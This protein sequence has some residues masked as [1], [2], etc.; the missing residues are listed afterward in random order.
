MTILITVFSISV[1]DAE[2]GTPAETVLT[3]SPVSSIYGEA[4]T[5]TAS[6][7]AEGAPI[8]G[9][10]ISFSLNGTLT[11]TGTTGED[12]IASIDTSGLDPGVYPIS[13]S[14]AGDAEYLPSNGTADLTIN[15]RVLTAQVTIKNKVY[16]GNTGATVLEII[17]AGLIDGDEVHLTF[18][19]A[20]FADANAGDGKTV[21]VTGINMTGADSGNYIL[22]E[23]TAIASAS[24]AKADPL[25]NIPAAPVINYGDTPVLLEG[26]L[27]SGELIPTGNVFITLNGVEQTAAIDPATGDFS[28]SFDTGDLPVDFYTITYSYSGDTNFNPVSDNSQ[29]LVV[30]SIAAEIILEG[31][32]QTYD[33][34]AKA[35][36]WTTN[37]PGLE[38]KVNYDG[39]ASPPVNAGSYTVEALIDTPNYTGS[40]SGILKVAKATPVFSALSSPV[41]DR[42]VVNTIL[43]GII[44]A[45]ELI[46][47]G[48]VNIIMN[49]VNQEATIDP[50]TG[51]FSSGFSTDSL[52]AGVYS[53]IY[54]YSGDENF[55]SISDST[56]NVRIQ[57]KSPGPGVVIPGGEMP[58]NNAVELNGF[59]L[60]DSL[61]VDV[62]GKVKLSVQLT[63]QD[64]KGILSIPEGSSLTDSEGKALK[65]ITATRKSFLAVQPPKGVVMTIYELGPAGARIDP[66]G[67]L[68]LK[69]DASLL[70]RDVRQGSLYIARWNGEG[71]EKLA[72]QRDAE[73]QTV[74]ASLDQ[75]S[76]YILIGEVEPTTPAPPVTSSPAVTIPP[77]S[78]VEETPGSTPGKNENTD[79]ETTAPA[80]SSPA[81]ATRP[82]S[83]SDIGGQVP[84][85]SP[86]SPVS[87]YLI[88]MVSVFVMVAIGTVLF[89]MKRIS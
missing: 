82:A 87:V 3:V 38:V 67:T 33:G 1:L 11:G 86:K 10:E 44:K 63:T 46:P 13:A 58:G 51:K 31:L 54:S 2:E 25:F 55:N 53:I 37:P 75:F 12:G 68:A 61:L 45:G 73:A 29:T 32:N 19:T 65:Q 22:A 16:D 49:D 9:R 69:Y 27:I 70:P 4:V 34:T 88:I 83:T 5:L 79:H 15:Q 84:E 78:T 74:S 59:V 30:N 72:S 64:E 36:T 17:P 50:E 23:N 6:L 28:S 18:E 39:S 57:E 35:V 60:T 89:I 20:S 56:R 80:S 14:W 41:I 85:P 47:P 40:A 81:P 26:N 21:T 43:E 76:L 62:N 52:S 48:I 77:V 7:T 8:S 71:W 24:I 66:P 42:G